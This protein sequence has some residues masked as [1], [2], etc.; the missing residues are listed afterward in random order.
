MKRFVQFLAIVGG[1]CILAGVVLLV[2]SPELTLIR[3]ALEALG[4]YS[5]TAP[6]ILKD[7]KFSLI[8]AGL[9]LLA[10]GLIFFLADRRLEKAS[11]KSRQRSLMLIIGIQV[12][13]ATVYVAILP[14]R[15]NPGDDSWYYYQANN[16]ATGAPIIWN[17]ALS[18]PQNG[19]PTAYWPIG[20]PVVLSIFFRVFGSHFWAGQVLNIILLA[21]SATIGYFLARDLL[22][23]RAATQAAL[24]VAFIPSLLLISLAL[25]S[26]LLFTFLF[27]LL[28]FLSNRKRTAPMLLLMGVVYGLAVLTRPVAFFLPILLSIYWFL[29]DRQLKNSLVHLVVVMIVG[30]LVLL[31]WQIHNY[32]AFGQ[33]VAF[34]NNGGHNFWMGNNPYTPCHG[35]Q[36]SF[37]AGEDTLEMMQS[38]N[39]A[40]RYQLT[41]K[42]GLQYALSH[43]LRTVLVWP[44]KLYFLYFKDSQAITW[45]V[46]NCTDKFPP[47]VLGG[48]YFFTDGFYYSL[49][50]AFLLSLVGM[51][52]REGFSPRVFLVVGLVLYF[53][54]IF[55]PFIT[56]CRY[57]L[58]LLPILAIFAVHKPDAATMNTAGENPPTDGATP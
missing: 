58:P 5:Y 26:D 15:P 10:T 57:H 28:L 48:L 1:I 23:L 51:W 32:R 25:L 3:R 45:A 7:L 20:Y 54:L 53:S 6:T 24:V 11:A 47:S 44:Q 49:G 2:V 18:S 50:L 16:L 19:E 41:F 27:L 17:H 4:S 21:G 14:Y 36:Y 22:G 34:S 55:L 8:V 52:R 42:I 43:P 30:E 35:P 38:L 31:P 33:F 12:L 13:I 9:L 37:I 40:Q 56:E 46:Q 39:E 29:K